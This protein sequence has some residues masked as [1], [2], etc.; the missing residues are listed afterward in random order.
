MNGKWCKR[1]FSFATL[2]RLSN[3]YRLNAERGP[4]VYLESLQQIDPADSVRYCRWDAWQRYYRTDSHRLS[5]LEIIGVFCN[6]LQA[7]FQIRLFKSLK[8]SNSSNSSEPCKCT[9]DSVSSSFGLWWFNR[10][11]ESCPTLW[12][13]SAILVKLGSSVFDRNWS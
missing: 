6:T 11:T 13:K 5:T 4:S 8:S 3:E 1:W 12:G 10:T 9:G 2:I 7:W